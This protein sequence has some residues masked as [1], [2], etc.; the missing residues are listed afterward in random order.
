MKQFKEFRMPP[1]AMARDNDI[2]GV[3]S[4]DIDE[5]RM[6]IATQLFKSYKKDI[7]KLMKKHDAYVS[8]TGLK[9]TFIS[10]PKPMKNGFMKDLLKLLGMS[11]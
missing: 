9:F 11:E 8:D 10:S 4:E 6:S 7:E 2:V 1:M 3:R 5:E